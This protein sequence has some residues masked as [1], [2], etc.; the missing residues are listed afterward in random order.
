ML[1]ELLHFWRDTVE[2]AL[3]H[4]RVAGRGGL[5]LV[6]L[7]MLAF[8]AGLSC[9]LLWQLRKREMRRAMRAAPLP[10]FFTFL[11]C[12]LG[13]ESVENT[14]W[15]ELVVMIASAGVFWVAGCSLFYLMFDRHKIKED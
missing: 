1:E 5:G 15:A 9:A 6:I 2:Y 11:I 8:P 13:W 14:V 10:G 4:T 3:F 12:W 7:C